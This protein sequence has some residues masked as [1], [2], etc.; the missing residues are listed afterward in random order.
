MSG[1]MEKVIEMLM[2]M[3]G[4]KEEEQEDKTDEL[5]ADN[6]ELNEI[7]DEEAVETFLPK[8]DDNT[9]MQDM[10]STFAGGKDKRVTLLSSIKPYMN[11]KR[12][13]KMDMAINMVRLLSVSSSLGFNFFDKR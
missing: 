4:N 3:L 12:Q 13:E 10:F 6:D 11:G 5:L 8:N 7:D 1:D 2:T 9:K